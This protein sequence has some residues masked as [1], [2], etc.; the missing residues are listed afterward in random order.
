[1]KNTIIAGASQG[2]GR[3]L[4]ILFIKKGHRVLAISRNQ[5]KLRALS[6]ECNSDN[7][8]TL[9]F[10]LTEFDSYKAIITEIE[11]FFSSKV[12][13]IINNAGL[14]VHKPFMEL[15]I[16][17]FQSTYATNVFSIVRLLQVSI[18]FMKSKSHIVN[19]SSI[20]GM[21]RTLKFTGLA[22]YSSSKAALN[23]MTELL[24][25]ELKEQE[26][27]ANALALGAVQTEM[28]EKAF[29]DFK[30]PTT[31]KQMAEFI[32]QFATTHG[33]LINGKIIPVSSTTP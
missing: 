27:H 15:T 25:E 21:E 24:A 3:E 10:D 19:I 18:P 17:D 13:I 11:S 22:A 6:E 9:P 23:N 4:A 2:I 32:Y 12:D 20:G 8:K 31:A 29:P 28:L 33:L 7:L 26:I 1:M 5:D 14:L 16:D 30:A